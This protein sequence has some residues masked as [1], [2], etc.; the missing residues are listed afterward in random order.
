MKLLLTYTLTRIH[1][2][3]IE[4]ADVTAPTCDLLY[5]RHTTHVEAGGMMVGIM[6]DD[7]YRAD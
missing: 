6:Y 7:P 5:A 2:S 4:F 1:V 3:I